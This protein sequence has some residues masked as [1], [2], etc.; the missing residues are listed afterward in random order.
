M[1]KSIII[2]AIDPQ[3]GVPGRS[4]QDIPMPAPVCISFV[5]D[6]K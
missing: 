4:G 2:Y 6:N 3:T 5:T 1:R